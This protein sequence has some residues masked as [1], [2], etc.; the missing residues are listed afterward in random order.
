M[1]LL[2]TELD[3]AI[4]LQAQIQFGSQIRRQG[5]V[6]TVDASA[7]QLRARKAAPPYK[8]RVDF[9]QVAAFWIDNANS[10]RLPSKAY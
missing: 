1:R 8:S 4:A 10:S 5:C 6:V 3:A 9:D 7:E 2:R